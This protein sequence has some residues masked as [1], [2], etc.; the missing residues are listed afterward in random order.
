M[1]RSPL[2]K[3]SLKRQWTNTILIIHDFA[4]SH[5]LFT[6][7]RANTTSKGK[8]VEVGAGKRNRHVAVRED[9]AANDG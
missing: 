7:P 1:A 3:K 4:S 2:L 6:M 5:S 8:L 9:S